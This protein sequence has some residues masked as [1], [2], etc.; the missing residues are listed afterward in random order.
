MCMLVAHPQ[1]ELKTLVG[2]RHRLNEFGMRKHSKPD[3][4]RLIG[5]FFDSELCGRMV[6]PFTNRKVI[7]PG[8]LVD[9][10]VFVGIALQVLPA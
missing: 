5:H 4:S 2:G 1:L 7:S 9:T 10:T 6:P 3:N 8:C